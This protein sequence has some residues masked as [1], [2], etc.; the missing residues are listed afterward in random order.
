M[1]TRRPL[2]LKSNEQY[3]LD[4]GQKNFDP[5]R[6]EK[7]GMLYTRGEETDEKQ[8]AK[9]HA[10]FDNGVRWIVKLER[11]RKYLD[12]GSRIVEVLAKDPKPILDTINR[13]LKMSDSD[14]S[15]GD[16]VCKLLD[17]CTNGSTRFYVHIS[18]TNNLT[19]YICVE[20]ITEAF[21][22]IDYDASRLDDAPCNALCGV[23]YLWVH[24]KYRRTKIATCLIDIARANLYDQKIV[25]RSRVAV[26]DP[27]PQAIPLFNAYLRNL[28]KIKV[29]QK[30]L[31][32]I[33]TR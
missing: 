15:A 23:L 30:E 31:N 33:R 17:N 25:S 29:Y 2:L 6:C 24:P 20:Q 13:L 11:A 4:F 8:H 21:E 7:C 27:T 5:I 32:P 3:C 1:K 26:C 9:Y 14:M 18:N 12:D 28:R 19:G 22:L 16:D 10:E